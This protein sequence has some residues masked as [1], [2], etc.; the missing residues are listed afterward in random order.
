MLKVIHFQ[1]RP[2]PKGFSIERLFVAIREAMS[3]DV[4]CHVHVSRFVSRGFF[5]RLYNVVEAR[6]HSGT[7][8]HITGDVHFLAFGLPRRNTILTI[9]DCG[10]LH[11][12]SGWKRA[13]LK[14][15]WFS[16]PML[17][18]KIV[19]AIS[20]ATRAELIEL[21]GTIACK[22]TVVPDCITPDFKPFPKP[23][24]TQTPTILMVGTNPNKN[25]E[26]MAQ[27]LAGLDVKVELIGAPKPEQIEAFAR[28]GVP[29][30]PL[31]RLS[32]AVVVEAYKR[33]DL[34][35]F[36][37]TFEGFGMPILEAQVTGRPVVTSDCSSMPE[38]AEDSACL[39]DPFSVESIREGVVKVLTNADY[40]NELIEKGYRNADRFSAQKIAE[41]YADLY[42]IIVIDLT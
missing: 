41:Q 25:L 18:A 5:R 13:V 32:D 17:R 20:A 16:G 30:K 26:R 29:F 37:S 7:V 22:V 40:R 3:P 31:G 4:D 23:W 24:P 6:L 27:A 15:V 14:W 33:C 8:N 9:H 35:L 21:L 36:A 39:V 12:L 11:R 2:E 10:N 42:R 19:T 34:L 1:R 28:A 38:V